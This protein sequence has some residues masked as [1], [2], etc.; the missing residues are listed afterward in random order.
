MRNIFRS[1]AVFAALAVLALATPQALAQG[2]EEAPNEPGSVTFKLELR[3]DIPADERFGV[4]YQ[5]VPPRGAAGKRHPTLRLRAGRSKLHRW[6]RGITRPSRVRFQHDTRTT[7][8]AA[9]WNRLQVQLFPI[10]E[11][12]RPEHR[13]PR[14]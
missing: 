2:G 6:R 3:G 11:R 8:W 1:L 7:V 14:C 5:I 12:Q 9:H 4:F 13:Q 10:P